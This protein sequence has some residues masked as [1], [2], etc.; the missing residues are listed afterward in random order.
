MNEAEVK[1]TK[2]K[3]KSKK[4]EKNLVRTDCVVSWMLLLI[5]VSDFIEL[6]P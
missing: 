5:V 3:R 6:I 2:G 1:Y 4:K